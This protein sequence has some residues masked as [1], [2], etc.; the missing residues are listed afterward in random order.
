MWNVLDVTPGSPTV[1]D[2]A[3]GHGYPPVPFGKSR[4]ATM[5]AALIGGWAETGA[6]GRPS[7][8]VCPSPRNASVSSVDAPSDTGRVPSK[9]LTVGRPRSVQSRG[10]ALITPNTA[11]PS[12]GLP[13]V[14]ANE[15]RESCEPRHCGALAPSVE[16]VC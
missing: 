4:D 7:V 1:T 16:E 8:T 2:E 3:T 12:P 13:A 14:Y 11:N 9:T 15:I 5:N 6:L 10:D